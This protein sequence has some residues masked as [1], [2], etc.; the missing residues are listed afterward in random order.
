MDS[1]LTY[2]HCVWPILERAYVGMGQTPGQ[3]D[4]Q[5]ENNASLHVMLCIA[6]RT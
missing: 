1:V 3:R 4:G 5:G 2:G 6:W